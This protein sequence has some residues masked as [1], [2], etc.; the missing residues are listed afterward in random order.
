[1]AIGTERNNM[2]R[3]GGVLDEPS[4][5]ADGPWKT[6]P[7]PTATLRPSSWTRDR[8]AFKSVRVEPPSDV[9]HMRVD[10]ETSL[11]WTM[12]LTLGRH[13]PVGRLG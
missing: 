3:D 2:L 6:T 8:A 7:R 10:G 5:R 11:P 1:M 4:R 9:R 13:V 12:V